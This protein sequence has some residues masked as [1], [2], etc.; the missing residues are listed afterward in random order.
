MK[1]VSKG[2]GSGG[3]VGSK[4]GR[5]GGVRIFL[6]ARLNMDVDKACARDFSMEVLTWNLCSM[7]GPC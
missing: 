1:G 2:R 4:S 7:L 6:G 5:T 3:R